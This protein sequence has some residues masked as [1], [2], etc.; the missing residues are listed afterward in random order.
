MIVAGAGGSGESGAAP[1]ARRG[2]LSCPS[3]T[4]MLPSLSTCIPCGKII[5]PRA[6]ALHQLAGCVE[7]QDR[8][9]RRAEAGVRAAAL[10]DP[11]RLAVAVDV[12]GA[13]RAPR[14]PLGH[15]EVVLDR[16]VRIGQIVGRLR[17][18][19]WP[20]SRAQHASV[21]MGRST[22]GSYFRPYRALIHLRH[23]REAL[24]DELLQAASLVGLGRVDVALRIDRDA[25]H[26]E[27]LP[28]LPAAV[29]EAG[30]D[31]HRVAHR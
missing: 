16:L 10:A 15:L 28:G 29:A 26:G 23:R 1:R 14:P 25:V 3:V 30:E 4:Q 19:R 20:R 2:W 13:R 5:S 12:D 17:R 27:E 21:A 8:I 24:V 18:S 6:E 9:E 22:D 31:L 7:L 11:D